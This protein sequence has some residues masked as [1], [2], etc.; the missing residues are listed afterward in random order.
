MISNVLG[1]AVFNFLLNIECCGA[2]LGFGITGLFSGEGSVMSG[3][4]A[5]SGE[6]WLISRERC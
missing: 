3:L 1:L 2:H 6:N 5:R 4:E